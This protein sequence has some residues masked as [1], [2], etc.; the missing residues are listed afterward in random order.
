MA[1]L[2]GQALQFSRLQICQCE[3]TDQVS[4]CPRLAIESA[5]MAASDSSARIRAA[6]SLLAKSCRS[7]SG[8]RV[9]IL[10]IALFVAVSMVRLWL[11]SG[12]VAI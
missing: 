12:D 1:V 3:R 10:K 7:H 9:N 5:N 2:I 8:T 4:V 11:F 6:L